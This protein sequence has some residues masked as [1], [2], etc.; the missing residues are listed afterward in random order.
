MVYPA[1]EVVWNLK[2]LQ[3]ER[4]AAQYPSSL[5]IKSLV[6]FNP[7]VIKSLAQGTVVLNVIWRSPE[8]VP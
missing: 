4:V 6:N 1:R 7:K 5:E 3:A 2:A 8:K